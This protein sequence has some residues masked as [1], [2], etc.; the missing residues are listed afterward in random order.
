MSKKSR[1]ERT[2]NLPPEAFNAPAPSAAPA[3]VKGK[4]SPA[5]R[6]RAETQ[7][8]QAAQATRKAAP[9]V[10]TI[11]WQAEYGEVL[12]DLRRTFLIFAILV[13]AMIVLSFVIR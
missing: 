7:A 11:D 8:A 1:R 2:P 9:T 3:A 10:S 4:E 13:A 6:D 12:G 5:T